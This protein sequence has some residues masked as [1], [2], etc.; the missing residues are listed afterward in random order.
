MFRFARR[1]LENSGEAEEVVQQVF[2]DSYRAIHRF[3]PQKASYKTWLFQYAYHRA[4]NRKRDLDS[5]GFYASVELDEE[6]LLT[7][8]YEGAGRL[9]QQLSSHETVHLVRQVLRSLHRK[10]RVAIALTFFYGYTAVEIAARTGESPAAVRHNLYRGL[11]ELRS[12]LMEK[13]KQ[14]ASATSKSERMLIV[15]PARSL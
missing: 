12:E 7:E 14:R 13:G 15:D 4:L 10:Q 1:V 9:V 8:L 3:D 2:I 5:R 6:E 11:A